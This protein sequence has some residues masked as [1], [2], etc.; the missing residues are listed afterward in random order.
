LGEITRDCDIKNDWETC[1]HLIYYFQKPVISP[2]NKTWRLAL[3]RRNFL[4][5]VGASAAGGLA[6]KGLTGTQ[7]AFAN[8]LPPRYY[9]GNDLTDWIVTLGDGLYTATEQTAVNESDIETINYGTVSEL[10]ANIAQRGVMAHNITFK[11]YIDDDALNFIHTCTYQFRL[12]YLPYPGSW[13]HNAQTIEGGIFI[14]DGSGTR[15][16]Y[17]M[18]FQ[19]ILNP[20]MSTFGNIRAW[21]DNDGGQWVSSGYLTPD[22]NWHIIEFMVDVQNQ[23]TS[24]KI[25]GLQYASLFSATPKPANWGTETAARFQAEIISLWPGPNP[26]APSHIAE[27]KDWSW[28]WQPYPATE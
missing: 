12:P 25:D 4:K 13:P 3:N 28:A 17:G 18:A 14:W 26:V 11:R 6:A 10:K 23:A 15:L 8:S 27:F 2:T 19:W 9:E 16:D 24:M 20:W 7:T 21:S 5:I 1:H 22:T